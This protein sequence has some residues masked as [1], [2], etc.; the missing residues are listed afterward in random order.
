[1]VIGTNHNNSFISQDIKK[2]SILGTI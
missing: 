2:H 1:M